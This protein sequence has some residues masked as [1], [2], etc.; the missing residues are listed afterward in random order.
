MSILK[1]KH[2]VVAMLP[3]GKDGLLW[4]LEISH[5]D[6]EHNRPHLVALSNRVLYFGDAGM[7][8]MLDRLWGE[9]MDRSV[10]DQISGN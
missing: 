5:P 3:T 4:S 7:K 9:N 2:T 8:F 10:N 1:N 6:P